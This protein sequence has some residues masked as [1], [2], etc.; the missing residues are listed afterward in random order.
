MPVCSGFEA[1][2]R[3]RKYEMEHDLSPVP[4]I[5]LTAHAMIGYKVFSRMFILIYSKEKCLEAGMNEYLTKP[6]DK[7][8]LLLMV[9]KCATTATVLY[10]NSNP[11]MDVT[12]ESKFGNSLDITNGR[13]PQHETLSHL[14]H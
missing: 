11:R 4:I 5:A 3:I 2:E 12:P 10:P 7:K 1:T 8:G 6:L 9:H 14:E 13:S